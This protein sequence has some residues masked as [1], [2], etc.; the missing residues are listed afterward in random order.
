MQMKCEDEAI[1]QLKDAQ[2]TG[3]WVNISI[4]SNG[5]VIEKTGKETIRSQTFIG[6]VINIQSKP[7]GNCRIDFQTFG[8]PTI[9][10]IE[11]G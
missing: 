4:A 11:L 9:K 7:D 10:H 1:A 2:E 6:R 8:T 3:E 5:H